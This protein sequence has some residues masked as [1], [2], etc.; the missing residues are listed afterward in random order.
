MLKW[1]LYPLAAALA[2]LPLAAAAA[3]PASGTRPAAA[4]AAVDEV[5]FRQHNGFG[6]G[7]G[8]G[9]GLG[10]LG[11]MIANEA[12]GPRPGYIEDEDV[13]AG[14]PGA[15]AADAGDPRTLCAQHFRSF[16]WNSGLYTT[17]SGEKRLCP[18][19]R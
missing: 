19:L 10:I 2:L 13:E 9:L 6:R 5:Q 17:H 8:V 16:E 12:Y 3:P 11:A 7:L 18:Y 4:G 14:P 1:T 15:P